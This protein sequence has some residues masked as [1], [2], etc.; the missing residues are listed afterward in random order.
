MRAT[1]AG[2][3]QMFAKMRI[4]GLVLLCFV[5]FTGVSLAQ[6]SS[7]EGD[8]KAEDGG[9]VKGAMVK[10]ERKDIKGHYE[11]K[12]DKKGH[13]FYGGLPLGTY[14]VT[15]EIEG[16]VRDSVDNVRTQLG[17][18]KEVNFNLKDTAAQ[19]K[20]L[21]QAVESGT[22]TKEQEHPLSAEQK[23]AIASKGKEK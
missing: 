9:P 7:M 4:F 19:Q 18:P 17:D 5:A 12:S 14:K 1:F 3:F 15:L 13:Y 2:G 16:K 22:L 10:I 20:A 8:V 23:A 6:I 21:A 11:V